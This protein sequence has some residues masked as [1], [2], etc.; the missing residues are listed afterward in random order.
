MSL[1]S[2]LIADALMG[3]AARVKKEIGMNSI[4]FKRQTNNLNLNLLSSKRSAVIRSAA[5]L[6]NM[7]TDRA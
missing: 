4:G 1:P 7:H 6:L 2:I 5:P 3:L